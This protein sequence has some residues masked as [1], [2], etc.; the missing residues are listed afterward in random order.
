MNIICNHLNGLSS[1]DTDALMHIVKKIINFL[2]PYFNSKKIE[3]K[4]LDKI[5]S[6]NA[7]SLYNLMKNLEK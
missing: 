5:R 7:S 3:N 6:D 1:K 4:Y 2:S